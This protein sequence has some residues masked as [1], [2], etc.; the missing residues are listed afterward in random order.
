MRGGDRHLI[1]G[2]VNVATQPL[3]F[4]T[5]QPPVRAVL[6]CGNPGTDASS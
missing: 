2:M 5:R 4:L 1:T 3:C 6:C